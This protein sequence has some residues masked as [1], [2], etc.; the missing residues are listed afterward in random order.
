MEKVAIGR[1]IAILQ[2]IRRTQG[3]LPFLNVSVSL[4]IRRVAKIIKIKT[5]I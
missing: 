1:K 3:T 5:A 4:K 2:E